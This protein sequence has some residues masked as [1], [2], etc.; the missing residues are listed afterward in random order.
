MALAVC[1]MLLPVACNPAFLIQHAGGFTEPL[2]PDG[3]PQYASCGF[4]TAV[5][6]GVAL[7]AP[8]SIRSP[9]TSRFGWRPNPTGPGWDCHTGIDY[10]LPEGT[11]VLAASAGKVV[12]ANNG[13]AYGLLVRLEHDDGLQTW[14]GHLSS[15]AVSQGDHVDVGHVIGLSGNTGRSTGPHLHFELRIRGI[16]V[17]PLPYMER[18]R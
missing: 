18:G 3:S 11:T 1:M 10:G 8:V 13:G 7:Q 6:P 5:P 15:L 9:I 12:F 17:D 14:Y 2:L 16:P 4:N